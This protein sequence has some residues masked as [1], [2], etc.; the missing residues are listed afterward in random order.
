MLS[1]FRLFTALPMVAGLCLTIMTVPAITSTSA[2]ASPGFR[3]WARDFKGVARRNGIRASTYDRAFK[4]IRSIDKEVLESAR[5]QPE[6]R[7]K[8]WMY[9]DTRIDEQSIGRGQAEK[10]RWGK[11]LARIER[12]YGVSANILLA[13]WSMESG[14]GEALKK[15]R[16][17]RPIIRSLA[18]LAYADR[19]RRKFG[20]SQLI[21]ALKI[22]Q[23]G[24]IG[25]NGLRGS[26][27]GAMGHTQFIPT[28]YRL[29]RQDMDGNGRAD[30]WNSVPDALATAANLLKRNGWRTG[31]TWGYE[32][33]VPARAR[34]QAGRTRTMAQWAKLGIRR[35][36]GR[37]FP[38]GN[39]RGVLKF[40]AGKNGPAFLLTRNFFILKRY[41]N[42]DK[43]ALAVGHLADQIAGYGDFVN[44]I[45]RPFAKLTF[46]Q[47]ME[48]QKRLA[49]MGLYDSKIDGKIGSGTRAAIRKAQ[50]KLGLNPTGF[51]SLN[52][53]N[54]LRRI[55]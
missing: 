41:N 8:L 11:W 29:Y 2:E 12:K 51:E 3:K 4:G 32:V 37:T 38:R 7:Q 49:R 21:A 31:K 26:W 17:M 28:S 36:K 47:K 44:P 53:L 23:N 22:L 39:E 5:Y 14:Y 10:R 35:V 30:I 45:P 16:A 24:D 43:Y 33:E 54:R 27:A 20:R 55:S 46:E 18:T 52:L 19:R 34:K 1:L 25:I 40:P 15:E 13:I 6:F 48:L 9:F 42:A 50:I